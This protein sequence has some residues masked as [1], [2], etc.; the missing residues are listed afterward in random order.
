MASSWGMGSGVAGSHCLA[1]LSLPRDPAKVR[2]RE[3]I[4]PPSLPPFSSLGPELWFSPLPCQNHPSGYT[5]EGR[6]PQALPH[7]EPSY[8]ACPTPHDNT[9]L[10]S[11][12][13]APPTL[14]VFYLSS[15]GMTCQVNRMFWNLAKGIRQSGYSYKEGLR[16]QL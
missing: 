16:G 6:A 14:T 8:Q 3:S 4:W 12:L 13:P 11:S 10:F 2:G 7:S 5:L 15:L 1:S 9:L